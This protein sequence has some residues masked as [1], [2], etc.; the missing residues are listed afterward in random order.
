M[1][2]LKQSV[3][4]EQSRPLKNDYCTKLQS[5]YATIILTIYFLNTFL[6]S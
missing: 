4:I 1:S 6:N 5:I 2:K 3:D